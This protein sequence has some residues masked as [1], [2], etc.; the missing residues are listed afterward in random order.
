MAPSAKHVHYNSSSVAFVRKPWEKDRLTVIL[1]TKTTIQ[2]I[3]SYY[4]SYHGEPLHKPGVSSTCAAQ[5]PLLASWH[6]CKTLQ[7][8]AGGPPPRTLPEQIALSTHAQSNNTPCTNLKTP[9]FTRCPLHQ[10]GF[11]SRPRAIPRI[12]P[13]GIASRHTSSTIGPARPVHTGRQAVIISCGLTSPTWSTFRTRLPT[14]SPTPLLLSHESAG[15]E[16]NPAK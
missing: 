16:K 11:K 5:F 10:N 1:C 13:Q 14:R 9:R 2:D 3:S 7:G 8:S 4:T 6:P 12:P 15:R